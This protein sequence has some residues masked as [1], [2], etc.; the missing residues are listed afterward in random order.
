MIET[1]YDC[2]HVEETAPFGHTK[3]RCAKIGC[4]EACPCARSAKSLPENEGDVSEEYNA[5]LNL[6]MGRL[7]DAL[8]LVLVE[9]L[10]VASFVAADVLGAW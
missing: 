1:D 2:D 8:T 6:R 4:M 5:E 9:V 7:F 10:L 3:E